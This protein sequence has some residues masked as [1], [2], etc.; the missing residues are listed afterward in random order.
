MSCYIKLHIWEA[1]LKARA[2]VILFLYKQG[3]TPE[4][5]A[6]ILSMD[7]EQVSSIMKS[8]RQNSDDFFYAPYGD[9]ERDE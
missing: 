7:A 8:I 5:I 4:E 1:F 2:G 6:I 3:K 9:K